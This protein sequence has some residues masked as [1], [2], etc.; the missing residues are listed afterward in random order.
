MVA[1]FDLHPATS[2]AL[3][4]TPSSGRSTIFGRLLQNTVR[5]DKLLRQA[6]EEGRSESFY[7]DLPY[8]HLHPYH[9]RSL[10]C[11]SL[12][13][14]V[15]L[16]DWNDV[17]RVVGYGGDRE[18]YVNEVRDCNRLKDVIR[19]LFMSD[20]VVIVLE[21][22]SFEKYDEMINE[23]ITC[24]QVTGIKHVIVCLNKILKENVGELT[25]KTRKKLVKSGVMK[26]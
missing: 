17:C 9:A 4:G 20:V 21:K 5:L 14:N 7:A 22:S 13:I 6:M 15:K 24:S 19:T 12:K 8:V 25:E 18:L 23:M 11:R 10:T 1:Q 3:L 2:V 16:N 26:I